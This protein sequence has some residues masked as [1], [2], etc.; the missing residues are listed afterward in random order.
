MF[1][2]HHTHRFQCPSLC[3]AQH[4]YTAAP[5]GSNRFSSRLAVHMLIQLQL[6]VDRN[7][8][9]H[10]FVEC[11]CYWYYLTTPFNVPILLRTQ[12]ERHMRSYTF[13]YIHTENYLIYRKCDLYRE[14]SDYFDSSR[15]NSKCIRFIEL[16]CTHLQTYYIQAAPCHKLVRRLY[17]A[18]YRTCLDSVSVVHTA[19]SSHRRSNRRSIP[20]RHRRK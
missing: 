18:I 11:R 17:I 13:V 14:P 16:P 4:A 9:T 1:E 2:S 7:V 12:M 6:C 5:T 10:L 15:I 20:L 8:Y 3:A 19:M